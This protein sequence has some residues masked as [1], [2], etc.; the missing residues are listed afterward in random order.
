VRANHADGVARFPAI[1]DCESNDR[2]RVACE[3][4]LAAGLEGGRP[5][6]AFLIRESSV[7]MNLTHHGNTFNA[8]AY[9]YLLEACLLQ[10]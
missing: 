4:V 7:S 3:V 10:A 6:V 5:R 8:I 2:A 1:T 9:L